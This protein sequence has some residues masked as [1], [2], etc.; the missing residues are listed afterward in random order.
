MQFYFRMINS[1]D[2]IIHEVHNKKSLMDNETSLYDIFLNEEYI[3]NRIDIRVI[4]IMLYT[5]VF[6]F[7][8]LGKWSSWSRSLG[9]SLEFQNIVIDAM[10]KLIC[11]NCV[12]CILSQLL[13]KWKNTNIGKSIKTI[14][15]SKFQFISIINIRVHETSM[16]K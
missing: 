11:I 9:L 8:F 12:Q 2:I 1:C 13:T 7:C 14:L 6:V 16:L 4:F 5:I 3:L 15:Q 10:M